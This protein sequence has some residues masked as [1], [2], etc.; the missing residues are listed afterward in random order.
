MHQTVISS[1][2][3][4]GWDCEAFA[5]DEI[6]EEEWEMVDNDVEDIKPLSLK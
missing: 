4:D 1:E 5:E 6:D 2:D 3:D